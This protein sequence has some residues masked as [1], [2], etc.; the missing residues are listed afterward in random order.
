MVILQ[1]QRPQRRQPLAEQIP[2]GTTLLAPL[3]L[4]GASRGGGL[5]RDDAVGAKVELGEVRH[6]GGDEQQLL[7]CHA[8][9][10]Q[11][12]RSQ[13]A[14]GRFERVRERI[15]R[16]QRQSVE[17][18]PVK[19]REL[20]RDV[21]KRLPLADRVALQVELLDG[22]ARRRDRAVLA[23]TSHAGVWQEDAL[24]PVE[25]LLAAGSVRTHQPAVCV[26]RVRHV[27][28]LLLDLRDESG[29][30]CL[31]CLNGLHRHWRA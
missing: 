13:P 31:D 9:P 30:S 5:E 27:G 10:A 20:D 15:E 1:P 19:P 11:A 21:E 24:Q 14:E 23:G 28:V 16:L 8:R 12:K 26:R 2:D 25:R 18:E 3:R 22:A 6:R 4:G 17:A 29:D 7:P